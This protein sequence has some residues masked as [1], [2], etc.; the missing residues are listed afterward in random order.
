MQWD[1]I[2]IRPCVVGLVLSELG[3]TRKW[4]GIGSASPFSRGVTLKNRP[5][6]I[7][8]KIVLDVLGE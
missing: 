2:R 3:K 6:V 4:V 1:R 7:E 5:T 8:G